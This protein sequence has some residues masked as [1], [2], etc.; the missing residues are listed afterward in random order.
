MT[1]MK[2]TLPRSIVCLVLLAV[3]PAVA[4]ADEGPAKAEQP[5]GSAQWENIADAFFKQID[6]YE[7]KP[8]FLRRC[9]G[10]AVTPSGEIFVLASNSHGVCVSKDQG[11]TW[12]EVAGN[13]VTGRCETGFGFSIAYP[14]DGRLAFF[15]IDGTGGITLD[16]GATWRPFGKLLRMFEFGDLNWSDKDPQTIFGLTH[17]PFFTTLSADGGKIWRQ[18]YKDAEAPKEAQKSVSAFDLGIVNA[19]TLV[20]SHADQGSIAMST[21]AGTTWTDVA[22]FKV[23]GRRPVHYG[24]KVYWTTS[25]GVVVSANGKDWTLTGQGPKDAVYGPYFGLSEQEFMVVSPK[26]FFITRDGGKTWQDVASAFV[27]PD[28]RVKSVNPTGRFNYFG[29]DPQHNLL[30]ASRLGSSVYRLKLKP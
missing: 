15:C 26:A 4:A 19:N 9:V 16:G 13:H 21:D 14:Y 18:L 12:A 29:W 30:Y 3:L 23:L 8:D 22:K 11:A 6:V 5:A 24:N 2:I 1:S 17:E 20:R 25:D 27:P 10:M 7:M 28:T